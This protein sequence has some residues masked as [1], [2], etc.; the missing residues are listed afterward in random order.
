MT[1]QLL[2]VGD[3]HAARNEIDDCQALA[4]LLVQLRA[5]HPLAVF[6]FLGDLHDTHEVAYV[7][8]IDFWRQLLPKLAGNP[9]LPPVYQPRLPLLLVGN[10][11]QSVPGSAP[12]VLDAYRD[13]ALVAWPT[14]RFGP[15]HLVSY[16]KTA[17]V[18]AA[19]CE[20]AG[21]CLVAHQELA[22]FSYESGQEVHAGFQVPP[23]FAQTISGHLHTPQEQGSVW[24]PGAPRW[25]TLHDAK[26]PDRAVWLVEVAEDGR[27][28]SRRPVSTA[29]VCRRV[30]SLRDTHDA[31][32]ELVPGA[33]NRVDVTGSPEYV[34][35]RRKELV[36]AG[37]RV[38]GQ[39]VADKPP[40]FAESRG[41]DVNFRAYFDE[42]APKLKTPRDQ[43]A[44]LVRD[45]LR[46]EVA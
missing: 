2:V 38:R 10:H 45:R 15:L 33:V 21:G 20:G 37:A 16:A 19:R 24:Y 7:S 17:D 26:V 9:N 41:V 12:H 5:D 44:A 29:G 3:V 27:V 31:P 28:A 32:A 42:Q 11:D 6:L 25:R 8:V 4:E 39:V 43:L 35:R 13:L 40:A 46:I 36:A 30:V 22:G 34:A 23:Q 18:F 14:L 1:L